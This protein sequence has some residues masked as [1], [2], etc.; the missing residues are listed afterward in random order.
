MALRTEFLCAVF[1]ISVQRKAFFLRFVF[2]FRKPSLETYSIRKGVQTFVSVPL[3][4]VFL[5]RLIILLS[6]SKR[7]A[8]N[9]VSYC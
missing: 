3:K 8:G 2:V 4:Q 5:F 7:N 9:F 1:L 6:T